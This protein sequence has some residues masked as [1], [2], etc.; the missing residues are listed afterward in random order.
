MSFLYLP[1]QAPAAGQRG[2]RCGKT[3]LPLPDRTITESV[4]ITDGLEVYA[5]GS[6]T[7]ANVGTIVCSDSVQV[8]GGAL[9]TNTLTD[10]VTGS[11]QIIGGTAVENTASANDF[12]GTLC[13]AVNLSGSLGCLIGKSPDSGIAAFS[14]LFKVSSSGNSAAAGSVTTYEIY[15]PSS[16]GSSTNT[17][18]GSVQS[19]TNLFAY[20]FLRASETEAD[21]FDVYFTLNTDNLKKVGTIYKTYLFQAVQHGEEYRYTTTIGSNIQVGSSGMIIAQAIRLYNRRISDAEMRNL[22]CELN[23]PEQFTDTLIFTKT[24]PE[25]GKKGLVIDLPEEEMPTNGLVF[26]ASFGSD[27]HTAETGQTMTFGTSGIEFGT[28][29]NIPSIS[30]N[31]GGSIISFPAD[32]LPTSNN[33]LTISVWFSNPSNDGQESIIIWGPESSGQMLFLCFNKGLLRLDTWFGGTSFEVE[34]LF[35]ADWQLLNVVYDGTTLKI[36]INAVLVG[37]VTITLATGTSATAYIGGH[38]EHEFGWSGYLAD[39]RIYNRALSESELKTLLHRFKKR[40]LFLPLEESAGVPETN[41]SGIL[42]NSDHATKNEN[43][44]QNQNIPKTDSVVFYASGNSLEAAESGQAFTMSGSN[45]T[46]TSY[47][48]IPT[49]KFS[50][51]SK[52]S[53]PDT[54][55][56]SGGSAYTISLWA[57]ADQPCYSESV[58]FM[59]G[60]LNGNGAALAYCSGSAVRDVGGNGNDHST[61]S[62]VIDHTELNHL[63]LSYDGS[64]SKIYVNG[65]LVSTKTINRSLTLQEGTIGAT[66]SWG[67]YFTGFI[68][69]IRVYNEAL[70]DSEIAE[71][72]QEWTL[73][74]AIN[75]I[76]VY[77]LPPPLGDSEGSIPSGYVMYVP[78]KRDVNPVTGQSII[79]SEG[80]VSFS[81]TKQGW[82]CAHFTDGTTI[83]YNVSGFTAEGVSRAYTVSFWFYVDENPS[84][85]QSDGKYRCLFDVMNWQNMWDHCTVVLD[86]ASDQ[87][88]RQI[89]WR[90][91]SSPQTGFYVRGWNHVIL[92]ASSAGSDI[93]QVGDSKGK[94]DIWINGVKVLEN[95]WGGSWRLGHDS[96]IR[97]A[98]HKESEMEGFCPDETRLDSRYTTTDAYFGPLV[99]YDRTLTEEECLQLWQSRMPSLP[100]NPI[101]WLPGNCRNPWVGSF[102]SSNWGWFGIAE[103]IYYGNTGVSGSKAWVVQGLTSLTQW[104]CHARIYP[105]AR[106]D[107]QSFAITIGGYDIYLGG[108][109]RVGF[110]YCPADREVQWG[111]AGIIMDGTQRLDTTKYTTDLTQGHYC[112]LTYDGTTVRS[113]LDG[114]QIDELE[115]QGFTFGEDGIWTTPNTYDNG[116]Y[117]DVRIYP[118]VLTQDQIKA[119]TKVLDPVLA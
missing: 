81:D 50:S 34:N 6:S 70:T 14:L 107:N 92:N 75:K 80:S 68:S 82:P 32:D 1:K 74:P 45:V 76:Y 69:S 52:L 39:L 21:K 118:E 86:S 71:L 60:N 59:W 3:Y 115:L 10:E 4:S 44:S 58:L 90:G 13:L 5:D 103:G 89:F 63:A 22:I 56:P 88:A 98:A 93:T 65:E 95:S 43:Y 83:R 54:G 46:Q 78:F 111:G 99:I 28:Y 66:H 9:Q 64:V 91:S 49:L 26:N 73:L 55:L 104:T 51:S 101:F 72:A 108:S 94:G 109:N 53:F 11:I 85:I 77:L 24:T 16:Y 25:I 105:L 19:V 8:S 40:K 37:S 96:W 36:Y 18:S 29:N 12:N 113:Y 20:L 33:P 100:N 110:G 61:S 87:G 79:D 31:R 117:G 2:I 112:T 116:L 97:V 57:K 114:V 30:M 67:E 41:A 38:P 119:L 17:V 7:A 15:G 42:L 27:T 106:T 23:A 62:N 48:G 102:S 47:M 84:Q 35:S